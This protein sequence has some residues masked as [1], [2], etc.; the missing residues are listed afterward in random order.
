MMPPELVVRAFDRLIERAGGREIGHTRAMVEDGSPGAVGRAKDVPAAREPGSG[1]RDLGHYVPRE[2][3]DVSFPVSVRG[4]DRGAVDA[5]VE[6]VNRAIAELRV[7]ASPPA[8]VRHALDQAG[9]KVEGLLRAAREAAEEITASARREADEY[10][11]RVKGEAVTL[12]VDTTAEADRLKAEADEQIAKARAEAEATV[13]TARG[14]GD[15]ILGKARVE[16]ENSIARA[17]AE[18]AERLRQSQEELAALRADAEARLD[19]VRADT[20]AVWKQRGAILDDIGSMAGG[21][22][23]LTSAAA[24]RFQNREPEDE[25]LKHERG[26]ETEQVEV[27]SKESALATP[28]VVAHEVADGESRKVGKRRTPGRTSERALGAQKDETKDP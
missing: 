28:A 17:D 21:L 4:Y 14:E 9:E 3:L 15:E 5:Y 25:T 8:A 2:L 27:A 10:A 1:F 12:L 18:A 6:H 19:E 24:A 11:D 16:A 23:Q 20:Q 13:A 22:L 7:R 26:D